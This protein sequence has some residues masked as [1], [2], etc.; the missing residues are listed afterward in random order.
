M[1]FYTFKAWAVKKRRQFWVNAGAK[2]YLHHV[3]SLG[4]LNRQLITLFG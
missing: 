4:Q 2:K 1:D 3:K